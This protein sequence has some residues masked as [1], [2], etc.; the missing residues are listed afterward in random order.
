MKRR[1]VLAGLAMALAPWQRATADDFSPWCV[2]WSPDGKTLA[3][4]A[5]D[6]MIR[7][8]PDS[9]GKPRELRGLQ[10]SV[11]GLAYAPDGKVLASCGRDMPRLRLWDAAAGT[12]TRG[13]DAHPGWI[14]AVRYSPDGTLL[15]TC[16]A[17]VRVRVWDPRTGH[18]LSEMRGHK[19]TVKRLDWSAD[20]RMVV[21]G[22]DDGLLHVWDASTGAAAGAFAGH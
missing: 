4:G 15:A 13:W 21:S 12:V 10:D 3:V 11:F 14:W 18:Q 1:T 22:G 2:A 20:G 8:W 19:G 9:G 16:G 7:L 17:D 5:A 6:G